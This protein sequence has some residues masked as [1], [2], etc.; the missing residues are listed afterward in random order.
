M[1][2]TL[3]PA[4]YSDISDSHVKRADTEAKFVPLRTIGAL[5][6]GMPQ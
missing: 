6:S 2:I 3:L 4:R 5:V 1:M